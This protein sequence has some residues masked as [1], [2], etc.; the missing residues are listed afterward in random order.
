MKHRA[1]ALFNEVMNFITPTTHTIKVMS[2]DSKD[3]RTDESNNRFQ[4]FL[5]SVIESTGEN[6]NNVRWVKEHFV[7]CWYKIHIGSKTQDWRIRRRFWKNIDW[8]LP[9]YR[10]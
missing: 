6:P 9:Y 3:P 8:E 1:I 10:P 4:T 7:G 2:Y 5:N